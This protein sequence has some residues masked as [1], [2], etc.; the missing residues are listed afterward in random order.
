MQLSKF[1]LLA[2]LA[3][4]LLASCAKDAAY[5]DLLSDHGIDMT[6]QLGKG[7]TLPVGS[8]DKIYLTEI[9]DTAKVSLLKADASGAFY[10]SEAGSFGPTSFRA[11]S[12]DVNYT[13]DIAPNQFFLEVSRLPEELASLIANWDYSSIDLDAYLNRPI[14]EIPYMEG[15][16]LRVEAVSDSLSFSQEADFDLKVENVD[17]ALVSL[18]AVQLMQSAS[19]CLSVQLNDLPGVDDAYNIS[20]HNV[21]IA[22][23]DYLQI[24]DTQ[25]T[26]LDPT[27]VSPEL[28]VN[29]ALGATTVNTEL[30]Y[31][32]RALDFGSHPLVNQEGQVERLDHVCIT[33]GVVV[34]DI[35]VQT[36]ELMLVK[37]DGQYRARFCKEVQVCLN[38]DPVHFTVR[39]V[40]G[41][42]QPEVEPTNI[43]FDMNLNED[44]DFLKGQEVEIDLLNPMLNL[45]VQNNS[46]LRL[47]ADLQLIGSNQRKV[48]FQGIDLSLVNLQ[49]T[50]DQT[51]PGSDF[52]TFLSPV[53]DHVDAE[54]KPYVDATRDCVIDLDQDYSVSGNYSFMVPLDFRQVSFHY[55]R[56]I[57][58]LWGNNRSDVTDRL[59][60]I[61]AATL[62]VE[63]QN[64]I[65]LELT[66]EAFATSY[67]TG[68][69]ETGIVGCQVDKAIAAGTPATPVTTQVT[70]TLSIP[71]TQR[72]GD[73]ILRISGKGNNC[74]LNAQQ[75]LRIL[76]SSI[77]LP[78]GVTIDLN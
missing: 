50:A 37:V 3:L 40:T 78:E 70:A 52:H 44:M 63:L 65:P 43:S 59:H 77:A 66:L 8:T 38:I 4:P 58:N 15:R 61:D 36:S 2:A 69:E 23:P 64:A 60:N 53:P 51:A 20:L 30:N 18:S 55:D 74:G 28:S 27:C 31:L 34:D 21:R 41:K 26:T 76:S 46:Q 13:F 25:G 12:F 67:A 48:A 47:M 49:L 17:R 68:L 72:V 6:M 54:V 29:K 19:L 5:D 1:G 35:E 10:L 57:S 45:E 75:Y 9:L 14:S 11:N 33:G 22:L 42:F 71:D 32:L 16:K 24:T 7:L 62:T 56:R 39:Q 73:L